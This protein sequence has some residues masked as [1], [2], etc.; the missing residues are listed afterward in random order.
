MYFM[1]ISTTVIGL[2][3]GPEQD[4]PRDDQT[5]SS[6]LSH[7]E[8]ISLVVLDDCTISDKAIKIMRLSLRNTY[9]SKY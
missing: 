5:S 1:N 7:R 4:L 9:S 2:T 3:F 8:Q 6:Y